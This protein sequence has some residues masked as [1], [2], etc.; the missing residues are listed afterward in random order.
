MSYMYLFVIYAIVVTALLIFYIL[1]CERARV[2]TYVRAYSAPI[3]SVNITAWTTQLVDKKYLYI[4][5]FAPESVILHELAHSMCD[6]VGHTEKFHSILNILNS[7]RCA[8]IK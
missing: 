5:V 2:M 8:L 7:N 4:R 6:D 3:E 1:R